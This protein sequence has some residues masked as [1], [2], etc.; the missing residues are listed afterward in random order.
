MSRRIDQIRRFSKKGLMGPHFNG[1]GPVIL[2]N[3]SA[4]DAMSV[5]SSNNINA[6]TAPIQTIDT[7][8]EMPY[9]ESAISSVN[10]GQ[11]TINGRQVRSNSRANR[12][13]S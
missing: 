6:I 2:S 4:K 8:K 11:F 10:T 12:L 7:I 5:V 1:K 9:D 13:R 3:E